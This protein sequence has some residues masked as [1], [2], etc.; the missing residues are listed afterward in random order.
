[1]PL[2]NNLKNQ[3]FNMVNEGTKTSN[4]CFL[5]CFIAAYHLKHGAALYQTSETYLK[6]LKIA[7]CQDDE[8]ETYEGAGSS[9]AR[10]SSIVQQNLEVRDGVVQEQQLG[11]GGNQVEKEKMN[12]KSIVKIQGNFDMPMSI[13]DIDRSEKMN[14]VQ[15]NVFRSTS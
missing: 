10:N 5:H 8:K 11:K 2:P 6:K 7:T 1:M 13:L 9:A 3:N 14:K 4:D 12:K 15:I